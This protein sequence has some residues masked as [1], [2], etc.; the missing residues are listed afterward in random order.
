MDSFAKQRTD[1]LLKAL[2]HHLHRTD[3]HAERQNA[4]NAFSP[5]LSY[6]RH[7]GPPR[8]KTKAAAVMI[9]LEP[10]NLGQP[11][12]G[13]ASLQGLSI[14]LTVRPMHLPDHP[15]QVS[16]PGG[17]L[18]G[19]ETFQQA[20][21]R[22]FREELGTDEFPGRVAGELSPLYVY[23]SDYWVRVFVATCNSPQQYTPC[24]YE[25]ESVVR[26]PVETL[27]RTELHGRKLFARGKSNW[28]ARVISVGDTAIWGA[29]AIMLGEL[30]AVL[31]QISPT[32]K[33]QAEV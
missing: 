4:R 8:P 7:F 9:M 13:D 23:N 12:T 1:K 33:D 31:K 29:T 19:N 3:L 24:D 6:G 21:E 10:N 11:H 17:R 20:A 15:G 32:S 2:K 26:L 5:D 22:E 28:R 14:P 25:V 27:L 18:E 30:A 16:L